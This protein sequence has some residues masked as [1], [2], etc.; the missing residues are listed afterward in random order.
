MYSARGYTLSPISGNQQPKNDINRRITMV[1]DVSQQSA[2][3]KV[4]AR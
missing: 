3:N 4:I 2:A 1:G